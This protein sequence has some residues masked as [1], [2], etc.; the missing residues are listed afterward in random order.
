MIANGG[1]V[2]I[3]PTTQRVIGC[4]SALR[5][6]DAPLPLADLS[7]NFVVIIFRRNKPGM[8]LHSLPPALLVSS[9]LLSFYDVA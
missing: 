4:L 3:T 8:S 5:T 6:T 1:R 9:T 2:F 7:T